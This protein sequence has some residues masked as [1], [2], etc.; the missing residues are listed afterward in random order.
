VNKGGSPSGITW[1]NANNPVLLLLDANGFH[2]TSSLRTSISLR[3]GVLK[4][5]ISQPGEGEGIVHVMDGG[6]GEGV[7]ETTAK[8]ESS[9]SS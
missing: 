7:N 4:L 3:D 6:G 5:P 1:R 2:F 8:H 9:Q